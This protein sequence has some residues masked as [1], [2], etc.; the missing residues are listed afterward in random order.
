MGAFPVGHLHYLVSEGACSIPLLLSLPPEI[1]FFFFRTEKP[2]Q[3][4]RALGVGYK[5]VFR[6]LKKKKNHCIY[7]TSFRVSKA[8]FNF[9]ICLFFLLL[10]SL[11]YFNWVVT[12]L[13]LCIQCAVP[14]LLLSLVRSQGRGC[15]R[16]Q[17]Y[18]HFTG[19]DSALPAGTQT[20]RQRATYEGVTMTCG[21]NCVHSTVAWEMLTSLRVQQG[22][23]M[24][25]V[26]RHLGKAFS[27]PP[28]SHSP[29]TCKIRLG[30]ENRFKFFFLT[31]LA[32]II[33][34]F[35]KW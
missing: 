22:F 23:S 32:L 28:S 11:F 31:L 35:V 15:A 24:P 16:V 13:A 5:N 14:P 25:W 27:S 29:L 7:L 2:N 9:L 18:L 8:H 21:W 1:L 6:H 4:Y 19:L 20:A 34:S 3:M 17:V 12:V 26:A 30:E 10:F 33:V